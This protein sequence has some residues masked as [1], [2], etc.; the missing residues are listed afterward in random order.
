MVEVSRNR[1]RRF[2]A[3]QP[4]GTTYPGRG[5]GEVTASVR[6]ADALGNDGCFLGLQQW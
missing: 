1:A 6:R 5:Q 3:E 2:I 4:A